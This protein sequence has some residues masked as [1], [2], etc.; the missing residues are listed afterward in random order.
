MTYDRALRQVGEFGRYQRRIYLLLCLPIF[1]SAMQVMV[2]VFILGTPK[3]RC[4][5]SENDTYAIQGPAHQRLVNLSV[6]PA[7]APLTY[8]QCD[9]YSYHS[10]NESDPVHSSFVRKCSR[11]VYDQTDFLT[12]FVTETDLVCHKKSYVTHTVMSFMAGFMVGAFAAGVVADSLGRKKGLLLSLVLH[13]LPNIVVTFTSDLLSF[14]CL[15]FLSG[16]SVGG[17][18]A[19]TFTMIME[20]VGPSYRM[21]AGIALELF[22][23][24]GAIVLALLAY[25]IRD[26]RYLNLAVSLPALLFIP[27][28]CI[29]PES[30]RWLLTK[31]REQEAEDILRHA[32]KV[33]DKTL[34]EKLF[35][36]EDSFENDRCVPIWKLCVT[37]TLLVR[38]VIIF[39]NWMVVS[40]LF[41]GLSLNVGNLGGDIYINFFLSSLAE[42]VGYS[43]PLVALRCLGRKPVYV[44]S[45]LLG[46]AACILTIFPVLY[47]NS[48]AQWSV[49]G[50]SV[51]GKVG[52]STAF[53]TIYL[54]S[55]ELFPTVV[56][57]SAMG[58][59]SLCARI[60]GMISPYIAVIN[61]VVGG[62]LGVAMP[63]V[64]FGLFA[65]VAGLLALSLPETKGRHLP[66]SIK[67]SIK[68]TNQT[69]Y[70]TENGV[71]EASHPLTP[72]KEGVS[73]K[74]EK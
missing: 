48:S 18:L 55:A 17:L 64:V 26:W 24:C 72:P 30:S 31:G 32:A 65:F 69:I 3:H 62:D 52:A 1:T 28:V 53:A 43:A 35:D 71:N 15:R 73:F 61:E 41:F 8:S 54:F 19:V 21:I 58:V 6:P 20:L 66:E 38:S 57:N 11:W 36:Y 51:I 23:A 12:T 9:L 13:I 46:G 44:T 7:E 56:R 59:S 29:I 39:F 42:V 49:V 5:I 27:Y 68:Y 2:T 47:G 34:P 50:L 22:W 70:V 45:L 40:M 63:L 60:G 37:P 16:A 4:A 74:D 25:L 14:M 67:D 10:D 33:N